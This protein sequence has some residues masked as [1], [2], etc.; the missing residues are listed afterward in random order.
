MLRGL[1]RLVG[2]NGLADNLRALG[3]GD[4][5]HYWQA[6]EELM[7]YQAAFTCALDQAQGG[8][9]DLIL[10]PPCSLPAFTHGATRDLGLAGTYSILANLLGYP[11]GIVPVTRVRPDE[12]LSRKPSR[13]AVLKAAYTVER[14]SAGLPICVQVI[15]RPW[16]EH[17]ALAGMQAIE[18][19]ARQRPDFPTT[20]V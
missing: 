15:A 6:V 14:G 13:D 17:I 2:Q 4:T 20:P 7:D 19:A 16:R 11:A 9:L 3:H 18:L 5:H 10:C 1:L 8:P 12:E